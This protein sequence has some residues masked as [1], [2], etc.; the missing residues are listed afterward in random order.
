M[1]TFDHSDVPAEPSYRAGIRIVGSLAP[2]AEVT[3]GAELGITYQHDPLMLFSEKTRS[4][5]FHPMRVEILDH[6]EEFAIV[7]IRCHGKSQLQDPVS[8]LNFDPRIG[9]VTLDMG[10]LEPGDTFTMI[11]QN[12]GDVER[13]FTAT[14][15]GQYTPM[16]AKS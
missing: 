11:V 10:I 16:P 4:G 15:Y 5:P 1:K 3:L 7:D 13:L 8:A 6:A 2:G 14:I 12:L 9:D